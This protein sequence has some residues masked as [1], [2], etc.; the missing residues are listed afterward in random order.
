MARSSPPSQT[1]LS[2][3]PHEGDERSPFARWIAAVAVMAAI[4]LVAVLLFAGGGSYTVTA[5]FPNAGQ[6]VN[7]NDVDIGGRPVGSV[8]DIALTDDGDAKVEL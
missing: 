1:P 3:G 6:L 5:I 2:T 4:V 8:K 7:G